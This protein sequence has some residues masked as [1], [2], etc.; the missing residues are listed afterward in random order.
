MQLGQGR[1]QV[2]QV[3]EY[4]DQSHCS[5]SVR[6]VIHAMQTVTMLLKIPPA[7]DHAAPVSADCRVHSQGRQIGKNINRR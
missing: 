6:E 7:R 5:L 3:L 2:P 1:F 4:L